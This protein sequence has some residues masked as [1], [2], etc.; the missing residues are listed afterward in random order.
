MALRDALGKDLSKGALGGLVPSVAYQ[1]IIQSCS[2]P[3][4]TKTE[5]ELLLGQD[6]IT[7]V[8]SFFPLWC[9]LVQVCQ[10]DWELQEAVFSSVV[11]ARFGQKLKN[12]LNSLCDDIFSYFPY[13]VSQ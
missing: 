11:D 5:E 8:D 9:G 12:I 3:I 13:A 4:V 7:S 10:D 2:Y 6:R 1:G